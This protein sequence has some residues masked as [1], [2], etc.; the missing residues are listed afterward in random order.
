VNTTLVTI[1]VS[2]MD[3]D[4]RYAPN[5][6]K[7]DFHLWEDG[8]EQEIAFFA[9][10]DKPFSVVLMID[11]SP[12]TRFRLEEIQDAAIAFVNQLHADDRVMVV[13]FDDSVRVLSDFT[14]DRGR[15]QAAIRHVRVGNG[16]KL[17][18]AVDMV[19][20][21]KL[22]QIP[23]RKAV[24]L[25]TDG[26]DTAS[27]HATY[28]STI[29]DA[30]EVDALIYPVEFDTYL[31]GNAGGSTWPGSGRTTSPVDIVIQILGGGG[32][33]GGPRRGGGGAGSGRGDYARGDRYLH[34]L[35]DRTGARLYRADSSQNLSYAFANVAEELR[36][37]YSLGYYPRKQGQAGQRRQI[38]VRVDEPNLAVR[39][40]DSYIFNPQG[41]PTETDSAKKPAAVLKKKLAQTSGSPGNVSTH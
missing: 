19:I 38:K 27:R 4:G 40:R 1:P 17:Y 5:L 30:E 14:S 6:R 37:Q 33:G 22:N 21:T 23:G 18:D 15:L 31:G 32:G 24:V 10:V 11:T 26:V 20:S 9:S 13:S 35:A 36:R 34:D 7:G 2:V 25:F 28:Q 29:Q 16:T 41:A 8:V 3:R 39:A 12:S